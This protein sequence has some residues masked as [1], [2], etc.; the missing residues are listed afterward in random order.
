MKGLARVHLLDSIQSGL[1]WGKKK[2]EKKN[3]QPDHWIQKVR[4]LSSILL[5][6]RQGFQDRWGRIE[7]GGWRTTTAGGREKLEASEVL[8]PNPP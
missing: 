5:Y 2:R 4:D 8:A 6:F 7:T 1:I 3:A